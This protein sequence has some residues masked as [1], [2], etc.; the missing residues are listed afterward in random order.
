MFYNSEV[1]ASSSESDGGGL[2]APR[3][4][5]RP[6]PTR[7]TALTAE[8]I[9]G[10]AV[11][12]LDESGVGGLSMRK[13]AERLGT[14]PASLYAHV[15]GK[16]ELLELVFDHLVGQ[17]PLP[18]P[19]PARWREQV[20]QMLGDLRELLMAHRDAALAGMGR[21]PT[22]PN[23]LA[24]GEALVRA[25]RAGGLGD[26]SIAMGVD[27]LIL[28]VSACA[29]EAGIYQQSGRSEAEIE[30]YFEQVH[31]FYLRL[32]RDRYPVLAEIAPDMIGH[33]AEARFRFGIDVMLAGLRAVTP[34]AR[35]E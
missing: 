21:V 11:T 2:P 29:V 30:Q 27:Q 35:P 28:Y 19:D 33:G 9:V 16:D 14:G 31:D 24:A 5:E 18:T 17:V 13:V 1:T 22:T 12:V 20:H 32:P 25:L 4:R 34:P 26:A 3:L 15:S 10:A 6:S 23:T 8:L 7:R